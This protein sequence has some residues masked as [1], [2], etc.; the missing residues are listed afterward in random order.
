MRLTPTRARASRTQDASDPD[1]LFA[2][3][4]FSDVILGT[5]G[6]SAAD[7][8][9]DS[10]AAAPAGADTVLATFAVR[11]HRLRAGQR[12][13]LTGAPAALCAWDVASPVPLHRLT[14]SHTD[15]ADEWRVTLRLP[16]AAFPL[17]YRFLLADASPGGRWTEPQERVV[18]PPDT[19]AG[20]PPAA[21]LLHAGHL[22]FSA[23]AWRGA[24]LAVPVFSLRSEHSVGAGDF[25][26]LLPLVDLAAA[27]GLRMV[28]LLPVN[29]TRCH[30]TWWDSYPY[31][32]ASTHALH[33][34]YLRLQSVASLGGAVPPHIDAMIHDAQT[35][36]EALPAVDYQQTLAAKIAVARAC[37]D[38]HTAP[39]G[40]LASGGGAHRAAFDAFCD[41]QQAW[42]RCV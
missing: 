15:D 7:E 10:P 29:D 34:L 21:L 35:R 2:A 12:V 24:G 18:P 30:G 11:C 37:F 3:S 27:A 25:G 9:A 32:C 5:R 4:A 6:A 13:C 19:L 42:L 1:R 8:V 23:G 28:Q 17:R 16:R 22:R 20:R 39:G 33:P 31:S 38:L 14:S 40:P 26:D 41:E 36:L